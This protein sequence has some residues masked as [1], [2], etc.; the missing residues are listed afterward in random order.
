MDPSLISAAAAFGGATIGG[1][2]SFL[3]S[4]IGHHLQLKTQWLVHDRA[5]RQELYKEFIEGAAKCFAD[6]LQNDKTNVSLLV[7]LY[8]KLAR[9]RIISSPEVL[10][11][12]ERV[13][14]QIVDTV[15]SPPVLLTN[16]KIHEMFETGSGDVLRG[17]G[18]ACRAELAALGGHRL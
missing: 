2:M 12:A 17:F 15:G 3:G 6:A 18:E 10:A 4:W 8:E 11:A 1:A 9:M 16:T 5:R 14:V 13:V 7:V